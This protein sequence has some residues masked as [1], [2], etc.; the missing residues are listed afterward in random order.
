MDEES[1]ALEPFLTKRLTDLGLDYETYGP[2]VLPLLTEVEEADEDDWEG[3]MQLLQASSES[4]C[5]DDQAWKDLRVDID[6]TWKKHRD[7]VIESEQQELGHKNQEMKENLEKD[8][9]KAAEAAILEEEKK[10]AKPAETS[11][12][13]V[14]EAKRAMIARYAFEEDDENEEEEDAPET[15][16]QVAARASKEKSAEEKSKHVVTKREEQ[17]KTAAERMGKAKKKEERRER[18]TKQ[19]RKS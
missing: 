14:D 13:V 15:N 12:K 4:H 9:Q 16:K 8:R 17:Q 5:D 6:A 3:V 18:S 10:K 2:Y 7:A 11:N 19:E 1:H